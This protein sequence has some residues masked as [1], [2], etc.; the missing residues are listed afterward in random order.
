MKITFAFQSYHGFFEDI[1][2]KGTFIE[3]KKLRSAYSD[4]SL[5]AVSDQ[6]LGY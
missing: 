2:S 4:V 3:K 1:S 5:H 6:Y